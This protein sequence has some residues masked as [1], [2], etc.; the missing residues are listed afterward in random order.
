M[1]GVTGNEFE[2]RFDSSAEAATDFSRLSLED[3]LGEAVAIRD[4]LDR[5]RGCRARVA[6]RF[7][8]ALAAARLLFEVVGAAGYAGYFV[9]M[10][11]LMRVV[12]GALMVGTWYAI[13][14]FK[15]MGRP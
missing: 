11:T 15:G 8:P 3:R 6:L 7:Q 4:Q 12:S 9:S 10:H 14:R 5:L 1:S 13:Y 2:P